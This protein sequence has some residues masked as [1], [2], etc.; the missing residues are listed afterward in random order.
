[1]AYPTAAE[2]RRDLP[3]SGI[4]LTDADID[5]IITEWIDQLGLGLPE[6]STPIETALAR[7]AVR[8]GATAEAKKRMASRDSYLETPGLDTEIAYAERLLRDYRAATPAPED[9]AV[10]YPQGYSG[11]MF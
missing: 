1:M 5:A 6:G 4:G 11:F 9:D 8:V 2:I 7:R 10:D 3:R